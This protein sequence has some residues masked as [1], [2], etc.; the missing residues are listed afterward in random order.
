MGLAI[1]GIVTGGLSLLCVPVNI[2]LLLPAVQKVRESAAR[3]Q[4]SNNLKQISLA[5][6]NYEAAN[7]NMPAA[8]ICDPAGKPLLSWRVAILPYIEQANLYSQFK[9][10][11]PWDGPNNSKLIA[12]MPKTYALPGDPP[13]DGQTHYRVF[14]GNGA[15]FDPSSSASSRPSTL[16]G[17][18]R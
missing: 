6:D 12:A 16:H 11:E 10:D 5:I 17:A 7:G 9:L 1:T 13:A 15:A 14:V 3:M 2:G 18:F 4:S 8:A